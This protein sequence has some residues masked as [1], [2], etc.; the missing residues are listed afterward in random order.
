MAIPTLSDY[1]YQLDEASNGGVLLNASVAGVGASLPFIDV[2]NVDGLDNAEYRLSQAQHEG[3]DGSWVDADF[4]QL[5]TIVISGT[6]YADPSSAETICDQLKANFQPSRVDL[7]F[8]FKH[9]GVPQR[10]CLGKPQG[11]RYSISAL[12]RTGQTPFQATILCGDPYIYGDSY[13]FNRSGGGTLS[14][15]PGGNHDAWP[16][17]TLTG[18]FSSGLTLR[19]NTLGRILTLNFSQSFGST[20]VIDMRKRTVLQNGSN[21]RGSVTG[22]FWWLKYNQNNSYQSTGSPGTQTI[23]GNATYN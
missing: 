13:S 6:I 19:N 7:P 20:T 16:I 14:I 22:Q 23:S 2:D 15:N 1:E 11:A 12:R 5:R 4:M 8:Y 9:P 17:V 18:S 21:K 10:F 3:V